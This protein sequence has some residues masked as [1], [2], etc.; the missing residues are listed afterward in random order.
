MRLRLQFVGVPVPISHEV[1]RRACALPVWRRRAFGI[2]P[3]PQNKLVID[4]QIQVLESIRRLRSASSGAKESVDS[5]PSAV[6]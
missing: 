2:L 1:W 3:R 6:I 5:V 4:L